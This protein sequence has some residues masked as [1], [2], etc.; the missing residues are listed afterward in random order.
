MSTLT[1]ARASCDAIREW[2]KEKDKS[3]A[4]LEI[5]CNKALQ[6]LDKIPFV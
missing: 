2:K 1:K 4:E 5:K 6:D 3:Y